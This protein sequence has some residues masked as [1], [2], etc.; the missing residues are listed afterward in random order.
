MVE[1]SRLVG[2]WAA[3]WV[4]QSFQVEV[5]CC[6]VDLC[7]GYGDCPWV[8]GGIQDGG[9]TRVCPP[10]PSALLLLLMKGPDTIFEEI[11]KA[12]FICWNGITLRRMKLKA[13][14]G[15]RSSG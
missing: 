15:K 5:T 12:Q 7:F 13:F 8:W 1:A 6:Q 10:S 3:G 4:N 9:P 2:W 11:E 14:H